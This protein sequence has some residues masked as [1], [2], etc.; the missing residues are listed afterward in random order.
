MKLLLINI[1]LF[2]LKNIQNIHQGFEIQ[3]VKSSILLGATISPIAFIINEFTIWGLSVS[4]LFTLLGIAVCL[5]FVFGIIV[6]IWWFD[7][8]DP[9]IMMGKFLVKLFATYSG[10]AVF[11]IFDILF[12]NYG[13]TISDY[14]RLSL[15]CAIML[16]PILSLLGN[17][18]V[19]TNG[20]FPPIEWIKRLES[21]QKNLKLNELF[22]KK[23]S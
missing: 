6:H 22:N 16:Y 19:I 20:K 7:D 18:S 15:A 12:K 17:L 2:I 3:K 13:Y 4:L 10:L 21:A 5:D 14:I 11:G 1:S 9:K 8:F 23:E